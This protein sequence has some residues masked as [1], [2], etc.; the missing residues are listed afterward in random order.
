MMHNIDLI[1]QH[2]TS[3]PLGFVLFFDN[4]PTRIS[5]YTD[6]TSFADIKAD[7]VCEVEVYI[8][9][10]ECNTMFP[11]DYRSRELIRAEIANGEKPD[12]RIIPNEL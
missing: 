5:E 7:E 4:K 1:T 2:I 10:Y 11:M 3:F 12:R 6:I 8:P 9:V